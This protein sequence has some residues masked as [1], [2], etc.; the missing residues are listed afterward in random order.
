MP[1]SFIYL[2]VLALGA[3]LGLTGCEEKVQSPG[4]RNVCYHIGYPK[5]AP[6]KFNVVK[7]DVPSV[8]QCAAALEVL[9]MTL[10]SQGMLLERIDGA[11]NNN[12]LF[13]EGRFVKF[14]TTYEG[15]RVTLLVKT[16]DGRLVVPGAVVVDEAPPEAPVTEPKSLPKS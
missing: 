9:R 2:G 7:K 5:D 1:K 16:N 6:M 12:F 3:T 15:P 11:Y 4:E 14:A 13:I 8:E 10:S